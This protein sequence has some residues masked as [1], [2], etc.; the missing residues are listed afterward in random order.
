[1]L[2]KPTARDTSA[3][4]KFVGC[5]VLLSG[6][7]ILLDHLSQGT[8]PD[9]SARERSTLTVFCEDGIVKVCLNDRDAACSLFRSGETL[10]ECI[11]SIG[12]ALCGD[13]VCD[14]RGWNGKKK[15]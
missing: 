6:G 3:P 15:R 12:K 4:T 14:W 1:M 10:I 8:W 9:G 7:D 11:E 5:P 13:A 2:Q